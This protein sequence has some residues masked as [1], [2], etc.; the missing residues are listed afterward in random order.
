MHWTSPL[1]LR[2]RGD[3]PT[4]FL[5]VLTTSVRML[6]IRSRWMDAKGPAQSLN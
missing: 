4:S 3:A 5:F 1:I 2:E 6:R